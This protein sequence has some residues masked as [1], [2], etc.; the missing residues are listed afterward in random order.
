MVADSFPGGVD[1]RRAGR[2]EIRARVAIQGSNV[3]A[4][5]GDETFRIPI[6]RCSL[7]RDGT[8]ILL[9]DPQSSLLIW[10]DDDGILDALERA[11]RGTLKEQVG[12]IRGAARRRRVLKQL[13]KVLVAAAILYAV[14]IPI[15]RWAVKG[16][17]PKV[18]D[19]IGESALQHLNLP[20]GVAPTVEKRLGV[21][22]EQLKPVNTLST[23]SVRVLLADYADAHSFGFPPDVVIV[24][25]G[26]VCGA[27]EPEIV[28]AAVAREVA[29]LENH[30]LHAQI[31]ESV[32]W[33]TPFLLVTGDITKLRDEM[34]DYADSKRSPGFSEAQDTAADQRAIALLKQAGVHLSSGQDVATLTARLKELEADPSE[35][36][37]PRP[38]AAATDDPLDWSKVRAEACGIIGR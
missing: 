22:A 4:L 28:T 27:D 15:T 11:Q 34:L 18:A 20:S 2:G 35:K 5:T 21:M 17:V 32:D 13:A 8:K 3:E 10:S 36:A 16:G 12:R 1:P 33:H 19:Q 31:A 6:A 25:S 29:H 9:R 26:L 24:T 37:P 7:E 30:D 38:A 14:S 23:H